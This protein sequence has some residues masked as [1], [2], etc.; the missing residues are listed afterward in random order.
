MPFTC[1]V[2]Y[3]P[4]KRFIKCISSNQFNHFYNDFLSFLLIPFLCFVGFF[5][6]LVCIRIHQLCVNFN[7]I[8]TARNTN[9]HTHTMCL[10][11]FVCESRNWNTLDESMNNIIKLRSNVYVQQCRCRL[12]IKSTLGW[13]LWFNK[14]KK[15]TMYWVL[16]V[17]GTRIYSMKCIDSTTS[18]LVFDCIQSD[19]KPFN[20]E[21]K[22][23]KRNMYNFEIES[24]GQENWSTALERTQ[25]MCEERNEIRIKRANDL[26]CVCIC[27]IGLCVRVRVRMGG[28]LTH[29]KRKSRF[30]WIDGMVSGFY[31][32]KLD[33]NKS[34]AILTRWLTLIIICLFH[35]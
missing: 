16:L 5:S 11:A 23:R 30:H 20:I 10:H 32:E 22:R 14:N 7:C 12:R 6:S 9:T 17:G 29:A 8:I 2:H 21:R 28:P 13:S 1:V 27:C 34:N 31:L 4:R 18:L 3:W 15:Y 24:N 33:T 26:N 35:E 25:R 19:N